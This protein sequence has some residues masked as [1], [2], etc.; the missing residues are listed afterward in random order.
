[1]LLLA[2][3]A[4]QGR[5]EAATV[6]HSLRAG[7]AEEARIVAGLCAGLGVPHAILTAQWSEPPQSAIQE[8]ARLERYRV[9]GD[10][11]AERGLD[12][13][14]TGHHLDDQAETLLMRL[15]RGAGVSGLAGMRPVSTIP[16][17]Q[18]GVLLLRPLLDWR[19]AQL[20][21]ICEEAGITAADDPSNR[22]DRFERVRIRGGL[23]S[24]DWLDVESAALSARNLADAD[25]ALDWAAQLEWDSQVSRDGGEI[26][27]RPRAPFEIRRRILQRVVA[28]LATEGDGGH[29]RGRELDQ[30]ALALSHG[31]TAT[32]RGVLCRGGEAW[33]F[34]TA[35]P[36]A[37]IR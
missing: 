32:L 29:L 31:E 9:L 5:I 20:E 14:A 35:P 17:T 19:H 10:W 37:A 3:E 15:N 6:D 11:A 26:L 12:A 13:I 21:Q 33:R 30:L 16:A 25:S 36:R 8:R 2:A 23:A 1:M 18:P 4:R 34:G 22:D 24:A 7:S 27:Y 28:E